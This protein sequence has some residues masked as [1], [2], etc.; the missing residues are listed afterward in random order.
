MSI[1]WITVAAQIINFLVLVWLL[2]KFLYRPILDGIEQREAEIKKRIDDANDAKQQ[3]DAAEQAFREAKI[4]CLAEQESLLDAALAKTH[5]Q[6]ETI[7]AKAHEQMQHERQH[8]QAS[9]LQEKAAF[10]KQLQQSA[11][12]DL[13]QVS[14]KM[15]QELADETLENAIARQLVTRLQAQQHDLQSSTL[16]YSEGEIRSSLPLSAESK[17][18]L[19]TQ[20]KQ[21]LPNIQL[22]FSED[23]QQALGVSLN[24]GGVQALWTIDSYAQE[25]KDLLQSQ[26]N[27]PNTQ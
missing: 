18:L 19:Q 13:L 14:Q 12:D 17:T 7:I 24:I 4:Q 27:K 3:A 25:L 1:D 15:V 22:S 6:R 5:E 2:K 8:W 11:A 21:L 23:N 9:L 26:E 10:L 20:I 16:G